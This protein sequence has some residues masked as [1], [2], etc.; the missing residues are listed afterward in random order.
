MVEL[1]GKI[2]R[3]QVRN[4]VFAKIGNHRL[5]VI[6]EFSRAG[7]DVIAR[8]GYAIHQVGRIDARV[9]LALVAVFE[10]LACLLVGFLGER[11]VV[12]AIG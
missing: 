8:H 11:L 2:P 10:A 3:F 9:E 4:D 1:G 12:S 6:R 7:L 5:D